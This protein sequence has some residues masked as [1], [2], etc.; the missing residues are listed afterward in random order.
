MRWGP[1]V[2]A[3]CACN[4]VFGVETTTLIDAAVPVLID[5]RPAPLC[6]RDGSAP[7][8]RNEL[9]QVPARNCTSYT[10]ADSG[11]AAALCGPPFGEVLAAGQ[12]D[13]ELALQG[14]EGLPTVYWP[15]VH[16]VPDADA[17]F[18][19]AYATD[20]TTTH[21]FELHRGQDGWSIAH[22]HDIA[23][24]VLG[25]GAH[26]FLESAQSG[27]TRGPDRRLIL[28]WFDPQN[29]S[30]DTLFELGLTGDT[31]AVLRKQTV[32]SL[33]VPHV[34]EPSMTASGLAI[35][36]WSELY[37]VDPTTNANVRVRRHWYASRASLNEPFGVAIELET[38]PA[39][40]TMPFLADDCGR[41]YFSAL[42]TVFYLPY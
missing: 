16:A 13:G 40:V 2:L 3:L 22:R 41:I 35:V 15:R 20:V 32:A 1:L 38:V 25:P 28:R 24:A 10:V 21:T 17:L 4:Q 29:A 11:T 23:G 34:R 36:F 42:N 39:D 30:V 18:L 26:Y 8:F 33:E 27:P 19:T 14:V 6:P 7:A 12:A 5:A 37:E 9:I 31:W